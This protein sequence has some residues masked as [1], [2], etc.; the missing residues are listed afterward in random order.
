MDI[1]KTTNAMMENKV[2]A[3]HR[4]AIRPMR[5]IVMIMIMLKR[6]IIIAPFM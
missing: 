3:Y 6:F 4:A 5:L 1:P 2:L